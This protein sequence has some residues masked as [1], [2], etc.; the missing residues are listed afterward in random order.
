M[1]RRYRIWH[2]SHTDYNRIMFRK[3]VPD[4]NT[5]RLILD[6]LA[7]YDLQL[8]DVI[9]FNMSGMEIWNEHEQ[10]WEEWHRE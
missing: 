7:E 3:E 4:Q 1:K 2:G 9:S 8:G 6:A 5:G 10:A